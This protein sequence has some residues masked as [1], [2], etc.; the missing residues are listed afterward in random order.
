VT[1]IAM[2]EQT[3]SIV[4]EA[5]EGLAKLARRRE[6]SQAARRVAELHR[7]TAQ[8]GVE[9][10]HDEARELHHEIMSQTELRGE[11]DDELRLVAELAESGA[12]LGQ[13]ISIARA[14]A[15]DPEIGSPMLVKWLDKLAADL[16]RA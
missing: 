16:A 10:T 4:A 8:V 1:A 7:R 15:G 9:A 6:V 14:N 5:L 11:L 2:T 12:P 3:A 13:V